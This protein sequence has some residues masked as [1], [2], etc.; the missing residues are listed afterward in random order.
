MTQLSCVRSAAP[1]QLLVMI[2]FGA[3]ACAPVMA[4]ASSTNSE[5]IIRAVLCAMTVTATAT[6][7]AV[8]AASFANQSGTPDSSANWPVSITA[9]VVRACCDGDEPDCDCGSAA[10]STTPSRSVRASPASVLRVQHRSS[11]AMATTT[12][13]KYMKLMP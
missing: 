3:L 4:S 1:S 6:S 9:T 5:I 11:A 13:E 7:A 2:Q 10:T 8:A 12:S